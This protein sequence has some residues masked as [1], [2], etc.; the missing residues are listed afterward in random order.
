MS[1]LVIRPKIPIFTRHARWA[2]LGTNRL[3]QAHFIHATRAR[4]LTGAERARVKAYLDAEHKAM[5]EITE[6]DPDRIREARAAVMQAHPIDAALREA[7]S[8]ELLKNMADPL[9]PMDKALNCPF[10]KPDAPWGL[11]VYRVSYGDDAA[12]EHILAQINENLKESLEGNDRQDLLARHQLVVMN[13]RLQFDGATTDQVRKHFSKWV[14][15]ELRRNWQDQPIPDDQVA[16]LGA[17][18]GMIYSAGTRYNFCLLVDNVCLE[19]LAKMPSPVVKL[20]EKRWVPDVQDLGKE[21]GEGDNS[22]WEGGVTNN[23]FEDVGWMYMYVHDYVD[24]QNY[25]H[26]DNW[27]DNYVRPPLMRFESKFETAPGFW[28]RDGKSSDRQ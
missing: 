3:F 10:L 1:H 28:R 13:N 23:E 5:A 27:T 21:E 18:D 24:I 4:R 22:G 6:Y 17:D 8:A 15:D 9:D 7:Y 16:K 2:A 11:V 14:V 26:G 12:W 25:L 19:S 20:V